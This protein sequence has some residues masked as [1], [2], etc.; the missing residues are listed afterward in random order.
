MSTA[1]L[2]EV[3]RLAD[4]LAPLDQVRLIEHLVP[5]LAQVVAGSQFA[6]HAG[7]GD[8]ADAWDE[9]LR[10]GEELARGDRPQMCTL[11]SVVLSSRW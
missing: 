5:R 11:T 2:D 1:T 3:I 6:T 7:S 10:L 9:F 4:D 8:S